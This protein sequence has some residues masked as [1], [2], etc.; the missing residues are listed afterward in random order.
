MASF[1]LGSRY[2]I[3]LMITSD[4]VAASPN[5]IVKRILGP[6]VCM[7]SMSCHQ[8]LAFFLNENQTKK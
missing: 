1:V 7:R 2:P 3:V 8:C 4:G 6:K 5:D